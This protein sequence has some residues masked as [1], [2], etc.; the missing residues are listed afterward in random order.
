MRTDRGDTG[1]GGQYNH[2]PTIQNPSEGFYRC[3]LNNVPVVRQG[4]LVDS[5]KTPNNYH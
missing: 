5:A 3:H 4:S 1:K 2:K